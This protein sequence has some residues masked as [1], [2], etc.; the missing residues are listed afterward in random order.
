[1]EM[2]SVW[3]DLVKSASLHCSS[4]RGRLGGPGVCYGAEN[5]QI[6]VCHTTPPSARYVEQLG[7]DDQPVDGLNKRCGAPQLLSTL[8]IITSYS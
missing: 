3:L 6:N 4:N 8:H 1:M 2:V 7:N 5:C